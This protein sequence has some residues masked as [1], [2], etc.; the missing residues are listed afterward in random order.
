[1]TDHDEVLD[2]LDTELYIED[3]CDDFLLVDEAGNEYEVVDADTEGD[4]DEDGLVLV[5]EDGEEYEIV[6]VDDW[7][8]GEEGVDW[9]W[10]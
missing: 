5:D 7:D 9:D 10:E 1:M 3:D 8:W 6:L 4:V 2:E